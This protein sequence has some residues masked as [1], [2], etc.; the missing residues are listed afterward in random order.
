MRRFLQTLRG[1]GLWRVA[2]LFGVLGLSATTLVVGGAAG[3]AWTN[4]E[5]FC[6]GCHSMRDNVYAEFRGTIHDQNRSGVR[7]VC[8]DCHVPREPVALVKRK[9]AATLELYHAALGTIDTPEKFEAR[10]Y[11]MALRV[12]QRMKDTDSLECRNCHHR[13]AMSASLQSERAQKRHA[14]AD[15]EGQTCI[16]CHYAI[17]HTEPTGPLSPKDLVPAGQVRAAASSAP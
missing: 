5:E 6:I 4:T 14:R 9:F 13:D 3:V 8:S 17:A 16:D 11:Q 7:A 15:S 2:V 10:R 12:W 1:I